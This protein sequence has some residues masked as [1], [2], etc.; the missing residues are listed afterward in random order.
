MSEEAHPF[1]TLVRLDDE[2][3][4]RLLERHRLGRVAIV[5]MNEPLIF[6]VNYALD[7]RSV[8]FRT[9][10]GTK[11]ARAAMRARAVFEVDE[12]SQLFDSGA[13][14]MVHGTLRRVTDN[15]EIER[16]RS[17]P[18]RRWAPV[19]RDELIRL[20]AERVSG[21]EIRPRPAGDALDVDGA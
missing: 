15:Q 12:A 5:S 18:L 20:E 17:L 11:L 14:V 4:W 21:R 16:L 7:G 1:D 3:C 8:V 10:P 6:P 2:E 9:A 13:S 19:G